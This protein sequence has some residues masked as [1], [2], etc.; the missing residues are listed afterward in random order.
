MAINGRNRRNNPMKPVASNP[1]LHLSLDVKNVDESV[2]FYCAL[3]NTPPTKVKPGYAK[4]DLETPAVNLTLQQASFCCI[5]GISHMGIRVDSTEE[6][7]ALKQR[8]EQAGIKTTDE[9]NTTCCYALQDKIWISDPTGYRWEVYVFKG[10]TEKAME[11][12]QASA[13]AAAGA[14]C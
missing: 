1:K 10:D 7:L 6:V 11:R 12:T 14:C 3:F 9:M 4:F 8:L 13:G 2:A 5:G